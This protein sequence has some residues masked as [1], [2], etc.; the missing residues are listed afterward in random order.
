MADEKPKKKP[1]GLQRAKARA[2][3]PRKP[4]VNGRLTTT[5]VDT[6]E[7]RQ[8]VGAVSEVLQLSPH[9]QV[10]VASYLANRNQTMAYKEAFP[11]C[12]WNTARTEAQRIMALPEVAA[13]IGAGQ[14][15]LARNIEWSA[16][17]VMRRFGRMASANERDLVEIRVG[18]CRFCHGKGHRYHYTPAE[19]ER[20]EQEHAKLVELDKASGDFDPKGGVGYDRNAPP[21]P[22]CPECGGD[23]LARVVF[24][25]SRELSDEAA[26]LFAG[27]KVTKDGMEVKLHDRTAALVN[28]GKLLGAFKEG[29]KLE[30][31][32]KHSLADDLR[33]ELAKR[34]SLLRPEA[35][36]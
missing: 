27:A 2:D 15:A 21:H 24:K 35:D 8:A 34:G 36:Q 17:E 18:A 20:A 12:T 7:L 6:P 26:S 23:G 11:T 16:E 25:D 32:V 10:F 14:V 3:A 13:A 5:T 31:E 4:R 9:L 29:I 1:T 30:G 33:A 22:D 19:F 28:V